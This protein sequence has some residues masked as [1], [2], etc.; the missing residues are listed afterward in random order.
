MQLRCLQLSC[1]H[2][3]LGRI[4]SFHA[5][6]Y[7]QLAADDGVSLERSPHN[8]RSFSI[9]GLAGDYRRLVQRPRATAWRLLRYAA[10]DVELAT[11]PPAGGAAAHVL[12]PCLTDHCA[13][14]EQPWV[15]HCVCPRRLST[16]GMLYSTNK[17]MAMYRGKQS[18][19]LISSSIHSCL[20]LC[21]CSQAQ[22][23][24]PWKRH[25]PISTRAAPARRPVQQHHLLV[26]TTAHWRC[27]CASSF[28]RLCTPPWR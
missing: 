21:I 12:S 13:A 26:M 2:C 25:L 27:S 15:A 6:V 1:F 5:Q 7:K 16:M 3:Y 14:V 20:M 28:R 19:S 8:V 18:T 23:A 11:V 22:P 4:A 17:A 9:Q 24:S 10:P